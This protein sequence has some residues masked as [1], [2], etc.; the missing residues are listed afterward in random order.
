MTKIVRTTTHR[1][2]DSRLQ[3]RRHPRSAL[4]AISHLFGLWIL[5]EHDLEAVVEPEETV[6]ALIVRALYDVLGVQSIL[7]LLAVAL[8]EP[9]RVEM[10]QAWW[11]G[12]G[13]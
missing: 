8:H 10:L 3:C 12:E 5:D 2:A 9:G 11:K 1:T 13:G 6:V 7:S 4:R